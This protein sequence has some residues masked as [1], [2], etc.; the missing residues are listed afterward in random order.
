MT[1]HPARLAFLGLL[2]GLLATAIVFV[3]A[4]EAPSATPSGLPESGATVTWLLPLTRVLSDIFGMVTVGMLMVA[5]FLIP[6]GKQLEGLSVQAIRIASRTAWPWAAAAMVLYAANV[7]DLYAKPL[8]ELE[9]R[10][11]W[12]F[13]ELFA[14]GRAMS[15]QIVLVLVIAIWSKWT[16][17][18]TQVAIVFG[19]G[20]GAVAPIALTGHAAASG[21]H[22]MAVS[23]LL[24]HMIGALLWVGGLIALI[25]VALRGSKRL[26]PAVA[27]YSVL[28]VWCFAFVA[29]SGLINI[30]VRITSLE[31]FTSTYGILVLIK[32]GALL[33]LGVFGWF[34]RKRIVARGS[35]FVRLALFEVALMLT[36]IAVSVVLTRTPLPRGE[37]VYTGRVEILLN[38]PVPPPPTWGRVF[39]G[40]EP[41]GFGLLVVGLGA[42]L[43]VTGVRIMRRR[44][45][46]WSA[47]RTLSWFV[48]LALIGWAT[49]GGL[50]DYSAV[51][52]SMHMISH[53]VLAMVAPIFL[54]LGAPMT[55]ALRTLPG[56]R[57]PGERSPRWMLNQFLHSRLSAL[58]TNPIVA[59]MLFIGSLY[60]VYFTGIFEFLMGTHLGHALMEFHFLASGLLFYYVVI[61]V[62]PSPKRLPPVMRIL[63]LL[64][65]LPFHAFFS[66]ALMSA[67]AV[68]AEPYF[69]LINAPY[70]IDDLLADQF[71]GAGV[72]WA[73]GEVPM[74]LVIGAIFWQWFRSDQREAIRK[75][76]AAD[77][78]DDAELKQYNAYLSALS[79][80]STTKNGGTP[81][82]AP[83]SNDVS[84]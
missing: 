83:P 50:G 66:V 62:D 40:W 24:L 68:V 9:A 38:G 41:N 72:A 57:V 25:W 15:I 3:L 7:A 49:F 53:M 84:S 51:M 13:T 44:G 33:T 19:L 47:A 1:R 16:F 46:A 75:D 31:H 22:M 61:G 2:W 64:V 26:E 52:F 59:S 42:A 29:A 8:W 81:E 17:S 20:L 48:G 28:A 18:P 77:R 36:T 30:I 80:A 10:Q 70:V 76:R 65:A 63:T 23:S 32:V 79:G 14:S 45:D 5:V 39:W 6:N 37:E 27:R 60:F 55:L 21:P 74:L 82:G 4:A 54:V 43:Y 67:N 56:P 11:L 35:N 12:S 71:F 69:R 73:T 78:D 58:F 34:Q